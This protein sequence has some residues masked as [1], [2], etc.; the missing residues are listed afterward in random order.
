VYLIKHRPTTPYNP[1]AN[2]LTE[3]ANGLLC[4]ILCKIVAVHKAD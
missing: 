2:R 3:Q 1:K 4:K